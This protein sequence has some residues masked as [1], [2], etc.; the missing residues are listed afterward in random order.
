MVLASSVAMAGLVA[1]AGV[2]LVAMAV[3]ERMKISVGKMASARVVD[4]LVGS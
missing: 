3:V 4:G 2:A 1:G